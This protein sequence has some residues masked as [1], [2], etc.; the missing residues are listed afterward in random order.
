MAINDL[1]SRA[2]VCYNIRIMRDARS[3]YFDNAER[4]DARVSLPEAKR[5]FRVGTLWEI[6]HEIARRLSLGE[7][8]ADIAEALHVSP[9][10]VSYTKNSKVVEDKV[11]IMR[12]AMDADTIDLG[13]KIQ[14]FAPV[15][16]KLLEDIISGEEKDAS[17]A[18]RARYADKHMDR[19][20]YAPVK[21]IASV[22]AHLTAE[23]VEEIKDRSRNSAQQ[24]GIIEA[25]VINE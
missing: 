22:S 9:T 8:N 4:E 6:H 11:A 3:R 24:A 25:E 13:I 2:T 17:I 12:A 16:L 23:E 21:R 1:T 7:K 15:A 14:K 19:A 18:L 10:M 5:T 20:G